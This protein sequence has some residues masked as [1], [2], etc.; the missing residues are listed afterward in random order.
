LHEDTGEYRDSGLV[1]I[2]HDL[3]LAVHPYTMRKDD[4]PPGFETFE[5]LLRF[6]FDELMVDGVFSDFPDLISN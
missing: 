3:G 6:L 1:E 4:L 2:A 5:E